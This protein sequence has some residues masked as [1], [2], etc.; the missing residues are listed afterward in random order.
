MRN[1]PRRSLSRVASHLRR[2]PSVLFA[3]RGHPEGWCKF[4]MARCF[5]KVFLPSKNWNPCNRKLYGSMHFSTLQPLFPSPA[6][7]KEAYR[8]FRWF[9]KKWPGPD[10]DAQI[11]DFSVTIVNEFP[12]APLNYPGPKISLSVPFKWCRFR[13]VKLLVLVNLYC[14]ILSILTNVAMIFPA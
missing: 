14:K 3:W 10:A 1:I 8:L 11:Q 12:I 2:A 13:T 9:I 6:P 7:G 4:H 5:G